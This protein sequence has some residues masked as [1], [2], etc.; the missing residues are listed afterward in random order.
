MPLL[1][2]KYHGIWENTEKQTI[3]FWLVNN[4]HHNYQT[5]ISQR[6]KVGSSI[7]IKAKLPTKSG[8]TIAY[9]I[10]NNPINNVGFKL[11][12][13]PKQLTKYKTQL[14]SPGIITKLGLTYKVP[15]LLNCKVKF[16]YSLEETNISKQ[17]DIIDIRVSEIE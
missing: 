14:I 7:F 6:G 3:T 15:G 9:Y 12:Y 4:T 17:L 1:D 10:D 16:R 8:L 2:R 13:L 5:R 11:G